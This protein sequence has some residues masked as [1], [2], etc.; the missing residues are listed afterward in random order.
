M[1]PG[2]SRISLALIGLMWVLPFLQFHRKYPLPSFYTEWLAFIL[3]IAAFTLLL[4]KRFWTQLR[5]PSIALAPLGLG[6]VLLIQFALGK[7][8]YPEQ[9]LIACLY[10]L[11]AVF[12]ALLGS[13]LRQE[14]GLAK[15]SNVLAW[16]LLTGGVLSAL[17]GVIQ[18]YEIHTMLDPV[19][20]AKPS[21]PVV[22]NL[23]QPN[24]FA[25]YS[26]LAL[27]SLLFLYAGNRLP[28]FLSV[29]LAALLLFV[30]AL[31]GSRSPWLYLLLL[32]ILAAWLRS[33]DKD[34]K[35]LLFFSAMLIPAFALVQWLAYLPMFAPPGHIVTSSDRL[36][37]LAGTNSIRLYLWHEAW[38]MFLQ[39]PFLGV[40]WGQFAWQ[41][42]LY[43]A[44]FQNPEINGLYNQAHNIVMQLL[45]ETGL[46]G[47]LAISAGFGSWLYGQRRA[48][49]DLQQWWI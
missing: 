16:F 49:F 41:N 7:I 10:L 21:A 35:K 5:L 8:A 37:E 20:A 27:A 23:A 36:F 3:G 6:A 1:F 45:A 24:S 48:V 44:I 40:G 9:L 28:M 46:A 34:C 30:L 32:L 12:L 47:A 38:L 13:V 25:D 2:F 39:F 17:I 33:K 11:W 15:A 19:I 29:I 4:Q 31:T 42:F 18:H 22:G 14:I 43:G 26:S